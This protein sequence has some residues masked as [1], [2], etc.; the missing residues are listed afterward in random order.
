M[1]H[2]ANTEISD[3]YLNDEAAAA[4]QA[5][6]GFSEGEG[7]VFVHCTTASTQLVPRSGLQRL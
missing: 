2:V 7:K 6:Q 1:S 3:V 4:F 5:L